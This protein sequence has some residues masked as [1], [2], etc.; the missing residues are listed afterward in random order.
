MGQRRHECRRCTLKRAPQNTRGSALLTVLW[1]AAALSA[2][3][4]SLA[5]TVRGETERVSTDLDGLR[6]YYL[7]AGAVERAT[8]ELFWA[9]ANLGAPRIQ[10]GP[11][12]AD[13]TFP[14]GTAHVELISETAK[15]DV[16]D[17]REDRLAAVLQA[18]AVEPGQAQS[19][20]RGIV[21]RRSGS[22][23]LTPFSSGPS[24]SAPAS[25]FQEI[26][27]L[28]SVPGVTPEIFYGTYVP[29]Q[30][31]SESEQRRL[32]RR[33]GLIDCLSVYGSKG[34]VEA[35]TADPAVLAAIGI[36]PD[37][38]RTLLDIRSKVRI[39]GSKLAEIGPLLGAGGGTLRVDGNS[40]YTIRATA[41]A[42]LANGQLSDVRRTVAARVKYMP[43][44]FD[45][46]IDILR[47]YDTAWSN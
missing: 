2:I 44:G 15:F 20:I 12:W 22:A 21:A 33:S 5:T 25:S 8:V 26:E 3:A 7:A 34:A 24:F 39:D 19:I 14:T 37:G 29:A 9:R 43:K 16:N 38:I 17:V 35:N 45:T 30:E 41:T 42:R 40:I 11:G 13:Y 47:W 10:P 23:S 18:M 36:P 6:A 46:W 32:V 28:L 31:G 4:F 27:E 1:I